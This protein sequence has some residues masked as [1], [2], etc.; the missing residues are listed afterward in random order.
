MLGV[1]KNIK[2]NDMNSFLTCQICK[3]YL[4]DSYTINECLHSCKIRKHIAIN[5]YDQFLNFFFEIN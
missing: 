1:K 3:G 4:V 2:L 5:F